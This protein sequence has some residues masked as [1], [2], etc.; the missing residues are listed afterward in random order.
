MTRHNFLWH[1][2]S[3]ILAQWIGVGLSSLIAGIM[4]GILLRGG[5]QQKEARSIALSLGFVLALVFWVLI[6]RMFTAQ[7]IECAMGI[8][9]TVVQFERS[10]TN[11]DPPAAIAAAVI[12][13][14]SLYTFQHPVTF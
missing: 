14:V 13:C 12:L 6:G 8:S 2:F 4:L 11:N 10:G 3:R 5:I 1:E 9:S 7:P